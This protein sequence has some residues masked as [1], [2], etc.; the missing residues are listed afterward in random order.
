MRKYHLHIAL[1]T[2][3]LVHNLKNELILKCQ[4]VRDAFKV[5]SLGVPA[6]A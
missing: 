5:S 4:A 1:H 2:E 6:V 3:F